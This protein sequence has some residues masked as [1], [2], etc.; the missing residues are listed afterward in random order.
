[1]GA[2]YKFSSREEKKKNARSKNK[3]SK[4]KH[5]LKRRLSL[6]V[7]YPIIGFGFGIHKQQY[8]FGS[9][10][11]GSTVMAAIEIWKMQMLVSVQRAMAVATVRRLCVTLGGDTKSKTIQDKTHNV[12]KKKESRAKSMLF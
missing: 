7:V 5:T 8:F 9:Q 12:T 11:L 1:M 10:Q 6:F 4:K 3:N 2:Y